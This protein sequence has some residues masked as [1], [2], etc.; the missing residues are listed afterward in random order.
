MTTGSNRTCRTRQAIVLSFEPILNITPN[1][2]FRL[3][4]SWEISRRPSPSSSNRR[5]FQLGYLMMPSIIWTDSSDFFPKSI[6][7]LILIKFKAFAH[8][9]SEAIFIR[10]QSDEL[11]VRSVLEKHGVSSEYA[12][13]AKASALNRRIRRYIPERK[14]LLERL[15]KLFEGYAPIQCSIKKSR[16]AF[17]S[18]EAK[19]MVKHLLDTVRQGYLSDPPGVSLYYLMGKDRDEHI[20]YYPRDQLC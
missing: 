13:R 10:D 18:D 15:E 1:R 3:R 2:T 14:V 9:F 4:Q 12:K 11:A 17:F 7:H 5:P 16:G 6:P 8:D 19:E 20:P